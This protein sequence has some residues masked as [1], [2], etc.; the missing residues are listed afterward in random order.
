MQRLKISPEIIVLSLL[1]ISILWKGGKSLDTVWLQSFV[2]AYVIFLTTKRRNQAS[3]VSPT[4]G[5]L[6]ILL[7]LTTVGSFIL[8][9]TQNYGFDEVLQTVSLVLISLFAAV[10]IQRN[11]AFPLRVAKTLSI[12]TLLACSVGIIVYILQ[13]VSRFSGTFFDYRFHTDYWPNAWAD[14][15]LLTWPALL[16]TLFLRKSRRMPE[17][18][19][20]VWVKSAVLGLVLGCFFLSYSRGSFIA[21]AGQ[22]VLLTLC[23]FLF[24]R[25]SFRTKELLLSVTV[26]AVTSLVVFVGINSIRSHF[27]DVESVVKKATFSSAEGVSSATERAGFW[28][29]AIVLASERPLLGW[30]PYSFR[31]VQP[32]RQTEILATSDHA[33]NVFLKL[34]SERGIPAAVAFLLILL[35]AL[36]PVIITIV[37]THRK[38]EPLPLGFFFLLSLLGVIAHNLIDYNLQFVGIALPLW[39]MLGMMASEPVQKKSSAYPVLVLSTAVILCLLTVFEGTNLFLSSRARRAEYNGQSSEA[40]QWYARVGYDFFPRDAMLS[41]GAIL[42][43]L[44][45]LSEAEEVVS[46]YLHINAEDGRAWRLLGDIYLQWNKRYDALRAYEKAYTF[47]R[48]NDAG[49]LRGLVYVQ[50]DVDRDSLLERRHEFDS[51]LNDYGLAINQNTHFIALSSSVEEV[52]SLC[53]LMAHFFPEDAQLYHAL[54]RRVMQHAE[55][56]RAKTATRPRGFLW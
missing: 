22:V 30:G 4:F 46:Q 23:A 38:H 35:F 39:I 29:E 53:D 19:D 52:V 31:F 47:A 17:V 3:P 8:S 6:L 18:F 43:G 5:I 56:E 40:L 25:W 41:Q 51:L 36:K 28:K 37:R 45:Q 11:P 9:T 26:T 2:A 16:W 54:S 7:T 50:E 34:A 48:Y 21:F 33:H 12:V 24:R 20:R 32:H 27:H 1:S 44:H 42:L 55:S 14:F 10:E 13:P 49:I 15:V